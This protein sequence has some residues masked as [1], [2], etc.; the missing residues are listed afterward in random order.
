MKTSEI[1]RRNRTHLYPITDFKDYAFPD[2]DVGIIEGGIG[3][4]EQ[5]E[6]GPQA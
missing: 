4:E 1:L 5:L 2:L 3:N 6:S